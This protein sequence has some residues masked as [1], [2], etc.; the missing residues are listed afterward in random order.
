MN[1][2]TQMHQI[3]DELSSDAHC[4]FSTYF[5]DGMLE[6]AKRLRLTENTVLGYKLSAQV[7]TYLECH[8]LSID[9]GGRRGPYDIVVTCSDLVVPRRIRQSPVV[10]VQEGMTDPEGVMF[11]VWRRC[12]VFPRWIA[13]T[14]AHGLSGEYDLFCVASEGY[15][16]LFTEKGVPPERIAVTGIPN[17][18][19]CAQFLDNTFP[20]RHYVLVCTSDCRETLTAEDRPSFIRRA[21]QVAA[22]RPLFFKL[23]PNEHIERATREIHRYA[24]GARVFTA[25]PAEDMIANCDV[26][27]TRYSSTAFVGL[28]LGKEVHSDFDV[29]SLRELL[30][31]QGGTAARTIAD[32]CRR[33]L[34]ERRDRR[35]AATAAER[36]RRIQ[37][38]RGRRSH[39][40]RRAY[41]TREPVR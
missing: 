14:A 8:R 39:P 20:Y 34:T 16:R 6:C 9:H 32:Q 7:Q 23:H 25:G 24:P 28:A 38:I 21:V 5:G 33:L 12:P 10:L 4:W 3:A 2:T 27:I 40:A 35:H 13:G 18:D 1:Q 19:D 37:R 41:D 36:A 31:V 11:R 17:F 15:R 30:P 29:D 22:G 26:L